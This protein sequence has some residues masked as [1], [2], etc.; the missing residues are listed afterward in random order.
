MSLASQHTAARPAPGAS[1]SLA[2]F[3]ATTPAALY[4]LA[5]E[6]AGALAAVSHEWRASDAR[7]AAGELRAAYSGACPDALREWLQRTGAGTLFGPAPADSAA[8]A[9]Q[10]ELRDEVIAAI[11][12]HSVQLRSPATAAHLHCLPLRASIVAEVLIALLNQSM[13]SFDQSGIATLVETEL[14]H[15]LHARCFGPDAVPNLPAGDFS[16]GVAGVFTSGGT[17]SNL[18]GLLLAREHAVQRHFG[19]SA[20][21]SGLPPEARG[22]RVLCQEHAH[23]SAAQAAGL[24]GLGR[25]AL[26]PLPVDGNGGVDL[27]AARAAI[28]ELRAAGETPFCFFATAGTTDRGAVDDLTGVAELCAEHGLWMHVDA[29]YG[30][31]LLFS[32]RAQMLAGIER[33]DSTTIDF[34][35]LFFQPIACGAFLV[36]DPASFHCMRQH[37]DYLNREDDVFPNLVDCSLATTRRFDALKLLLSFQAL[38]PENYAQ[39]VETL[40]ARTQRARDWIAEREGFELVVEPPF[41]T[42]L[43]RVFDVTGASDPNQAESQ[44]RTDALNSRVRNRLLGTGAA[45]IGETRWNGRPVLKL[46]LMN[47]LVS[48]TELTTL[49][50]TIER[51]VRELRG[52]VD[53]G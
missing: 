21:Q 25:D 1:K 36:R 33:A 11:A 37:A 31:G 8:N 35:K 42:V 29:A 15:D 22:L 53:A 47:P 24:L 39:A 51:C 17:Q 52:N 30:G 10:E 18:M 50:E 9:D 34:H 3:F 23:F 49:L 40:F 44:A 4:Q 28:A 7:Q 46:T 43:F 20:L 2:R 13:D 32:Q 16:N 26:V 12:R 48:D 41:T 14:I 19:C 5:D 38:G 6:I 27:I 45:I